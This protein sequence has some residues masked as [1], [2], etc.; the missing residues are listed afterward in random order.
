MQVDDAHRLQDYN[1]TVGS[2][3]DA[4]AISRSMSPLKPGTRFVRTNFAM[5]DHVVAR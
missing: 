4:K 1:P 5:H 3:A 2:V